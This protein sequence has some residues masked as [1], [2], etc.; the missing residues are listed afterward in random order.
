MIR[1]RGFGNVAAPV[2]DHP[3]PSV[4]ELL[5]GGAQF[6][7][8]PSLAIKTIMSGPSIINEDPQYQAVKYAGILLPVALV[9]FL[10]L[11]GGRPRRYG[12]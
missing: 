8:S 4:P 5:L 7:M 10:L 11:S 6:W 1:L 2:I 12:R 9:A 3:A